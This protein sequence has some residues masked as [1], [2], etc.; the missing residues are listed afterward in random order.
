MWSVGSTNDVG[1]DQGFD[2]FGL[3]TSQ[4]RQ[5]SRNFTDLNDTQPLPDPIMFLPTQYYNS[6][7]KL[8]RAEEE[9]IRHRRVRCDS[10]LTRLVVCLC[11]ILLRY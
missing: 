4:T 1:A 6:T 9:Y 3:D 8:K 2:D 10:M 5:Q 7:D 11:A